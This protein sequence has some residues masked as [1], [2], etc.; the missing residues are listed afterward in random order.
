MQEFKPILEKIREY[1]Q[2]VHREFDL[3]KHGL[4]PSVEEAQKRAS[5]RD[6]ITVLECLFEIAGIPAADQVSI[7]KTLKESVA[8]EIEGI[9]DAVNAALLRAEDMEAWRLERIVRLLLTIRAISDRRDPEEEV[10]A[11][12]RRLEEI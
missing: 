12:L 4:W 9:G 3:L 5:L 6:F 11:F 1:S 2:R 7:E 8:R 10:N